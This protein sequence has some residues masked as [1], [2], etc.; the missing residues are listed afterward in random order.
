[1][2]VEVIMF[3][4]SL[5]FFSIYAKMQG[6]GDICISAFYAEIQIGLQKWRENHFLGKKLPDDS[7]DS[8]GIKNFAKSFYLAP[9]QR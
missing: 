4:C 3:L 1:M 9:L 7:T 6:F 2:I 5:Y 8:L